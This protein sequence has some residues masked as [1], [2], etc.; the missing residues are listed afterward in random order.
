MEGDPLFDTLAQD[1]YNIDGKGNGMNGPSPLKKKN[2]F[3]LCAYNE[4]M[5]PYC[6]ASRF[7]HYIIHAK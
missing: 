2:K 6:G 4:Y 7:T 5:K 3:S 1:Q